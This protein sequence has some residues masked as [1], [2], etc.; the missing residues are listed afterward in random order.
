MEK[1]KKKKKRENA[2]QNFPHFQSEV[3]EL[4]LLSNQQSQTHIFIIA[5]MDHK[6]QPQNYLHLKLGSICYSETHFVIVGE[7]VLVSWE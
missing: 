3:F 1:K 7:M 6:D 4:L 5:I 2:Q